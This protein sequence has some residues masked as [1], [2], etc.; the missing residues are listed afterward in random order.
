LEKSIAFN[1]INIS[2]ANLIEWMSK[3]FY[4]WKLTEEEIESYQRLF[5]RKIK[6]PN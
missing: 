3:E 2:V 1:E 4:S 5:F 6:L